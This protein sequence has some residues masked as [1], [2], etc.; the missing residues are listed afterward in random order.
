MAERHRT[1]TFR[2]TINGLLQRRSEL[3]DETGVL[4]ERLAQV[5]NDVEAIDRV[6][7][8][9]G[10]EGELPNRTARQERIILFY[11]NE[12]RDYLLKELR[13]SDRPL[14]TRELAQRICQ[15]EGKDFHDRRLL[16]DVVKRASKA[17]RQMRYHG[18]IKAAGHYEGTALWT[19][20]DQTAST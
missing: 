8:T 11:R 10:Y 14:S 18:M 9:L 3:M 16:S 20:A 19:V 12:L 5:A 4:R 7:D 2:H 6:L 13:A 17:L 15:T 1:E